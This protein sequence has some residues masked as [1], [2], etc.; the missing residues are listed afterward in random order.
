MKAIAGNG[1]TRAMPELEPVLSRRVTVLG[2]TGSIGVST[3]S[4][5]VNARAV[6]GQHVLPIAA[7]TAQSNVA[8]LAEQARAMKPEIAVIGDPARY[9]ELR[10]ALAGTGI[11][12][13]AGREAVIAAGARPSEF[14]MVAIVGAAAIEPA[15]A[16]IRRGATVALANKEC[17]VAAGAVFRAAL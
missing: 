17:V 9:G 6:Y 12:V 14:V 13:A 1:E 2:A 16:A 3:L 15:L 10:D 8:Q 11:E 5:I 7:L 4:V